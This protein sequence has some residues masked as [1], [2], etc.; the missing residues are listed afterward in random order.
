MTERE[1]DQL[2]LLQMITQD[3]IEASPVE[4]LMVKQNTTRGDHRYT[5]APMSLFPTPYPLDMYKQG[6]RMQTAFG[7]LI[8]GMISR[9]Q[10]NIHQILGGFAE[11]D[12]FMQ[13]LLTVSETFA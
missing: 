1:N 10:E 4:G 5:H 11:H 9:P 13:R 7:E 6:Y 8:A 12:H 3:V 2:E